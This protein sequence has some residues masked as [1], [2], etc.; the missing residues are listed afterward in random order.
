MGNKKN[1]NWVSASDVGRAAYCPH[2]LELRDKG[3]KVSKSSERAR[4]RGDVAHDEFNKLAEDKR[5]YVASHLYGIDD[6]RTETLRRFRDDNLVN[7]P[8]N[9][10]KIL[11]SVYYRL[12]PVF[13]QAARAL[14][15]VDLCLRKTVDHIV[16]MIKR[17]NADD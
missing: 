3:T 5:C 8:G 10:G 12:S 1:S 2:Y 15:G 16:R 6:E 17:R 9:T 4:V 14:P 13:I 11:I 7:L